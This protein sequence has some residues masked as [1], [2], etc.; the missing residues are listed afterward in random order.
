MKT[1][2]IFFFIFTIFLCFALNKSTEDFPD[3]VFDS[4]IGATHLKSTDHLKEI[5]DTNDLTYLLFY[6]KK[7]SKNSRIGGHILQEVSEKLEFLFEVLLV[8]C[9][10]EYGQVA[11]P[12]VKTLQDNKEADEFPRFYIM[13]PPEYRINPYTGKLQTYTEEMF[14]G[15][16]INFNIIHN[17]VTKHITAGR[18]TQLNKE[19][20]DD[21]LRYFLI[22]TNSH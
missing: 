17:F 6:Y 19:N 8:D 5:L 20:I 11:D 10:S 12:C 16:E 21:F 9:D 4:I 13:A 1:L 14:K 15:T 2:Y 18:I 7:T 22:H 3:T